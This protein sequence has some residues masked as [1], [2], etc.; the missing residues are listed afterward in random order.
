MPQTQG[1]TNTYSR[2]FKS[3][4]GGPAWLGSDES[5]LPDTENDLLTMF[6]MAGR[7]RTLW[8]YKVFNLIRTLYSWLH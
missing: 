4:N 5:P 2:M 7:E 3:K 6:S 8:H 1:L